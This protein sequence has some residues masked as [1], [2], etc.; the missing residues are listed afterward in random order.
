MWIADIARM[1]DQI[2]PAKG[3]LRFR[4]E[5][6]VGIRNHANAHGLL[7]PCR[8]FRESV[9]LIPLSIFVGHVVLGHFFRMHLGLVRIGCIFHA[10]DH[11]CFERLAFFQKFF[12]AF[13]ISLRLP[14]KRPVCLPTDR[15]TARP[16]PA[17]YR[18]RVP[19]C[20]LFRGFSFCDSFWLPLAA[21]LPV[22]LRVSFSRGR[23]F[24]FRF[25]DCF[26]SARPGFCLFCCHGFVL[27]LR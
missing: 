21:S 12:D 8:E 9:G 22:S 11:F 2:H 6:S 10:C 14:R 4:A 23:F 24:R 1:E 5:Q 15:R 27:P 25:R 16:I 7:G 19:R 26:S 20:W 18:K 17:G 3:L 13:R